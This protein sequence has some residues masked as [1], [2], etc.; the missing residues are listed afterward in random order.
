MDIIRP[1]VVDS[2]VLVNST[3]PDTEY[4]TYSAAT[5]YTVG[6]RV[7]VPSPDSLETGSVVY[8]ALTTTQGNSPPQ[9][10]GG[11]NPIWLRLG[12]SNRWRM[13][14]DF[15][16]TFSEATNALE[17]V[18]RTSSIS[19]AIS[20]Y[21]VS[22][23]TLTITITDDIE[24]VV[25]TE[26]R[27]LISTAGIDDWYDYV[28][29]EPSSRKD[30]VIDL[31]PYSDAD[32]NITVTGPGSVRVGKLAFGM[33]KSLG[34]TQYRSRVGIRD[35]SRKDVDEFG[36]PRF[37]KRRTAKLV[38]FVV[39]VETKRISEIQNILAEFTTT[40]M[41]WIGNET[42]EETIIYGFYKDFDIVLANN[43][44]SDCSIQVEGL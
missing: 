14:D 24:G 9:H 28:F 37:M 42:A 16:S 31:P 43:E 41:T 8:E 15:T 29:E 23:E 12:A 21:G 3:I 18:L 40:P 27:S 10:I 4:P 32:I 20:L 1:I 30:L 13:F 39:L 25:F 11:E 44:L 17:V 2:D 5:N 7:I 38:N 36:I 35:F 19:N 33:R 26:T 34:S 22:G 6:D